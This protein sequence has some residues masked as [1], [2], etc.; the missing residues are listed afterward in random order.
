[1]YLPVLAEQPSSIDPA[2]FP[3]PPA[4][5]AAWIES[6]RVTWE[7]GPRDESLESPGRPRMAAETRYRIAYHYR[8]RLRWTVASEG[9]RTAVIR[10]R[11]ENVSLEPSHVIW[12]RERPEVQG[13]WENPLVLHELDHLQ[14]SSDHRL[15]KLFAERLREQ[16]VL[17]IAVTD[18]DIVNRDFVDRKVDEH[19]AG[20]FQ[21]ISDLIAIRYQEL[22]RLTNHGRKP[23]PADFHLFTEPASD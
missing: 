14:I 19:V 8:T 16:P 21:E 22:D 11:F 9:K 23:L 3:N 18:Q 17:R 10:V 1:M 6:G 4:E 15:S 20:L 7:A 2:E 5:I 12:F 13:F